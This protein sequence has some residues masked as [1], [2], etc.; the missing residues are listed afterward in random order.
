M[1]AQTFQ[2]SSRVLVTNNISKFGI[3]S[4][5]DS[6]VMEHFKM[7][8]SSINYSRLGDSVLLRLY[9]RAFFKAREKLHN[10]QKRKE[11]MGGSSLE[12]SVGGQ[13]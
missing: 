9:F 3:A 12:N 8:C 2:T 13:K 5:K 6:S 11:I 1:V 4:F 7:F 10:F